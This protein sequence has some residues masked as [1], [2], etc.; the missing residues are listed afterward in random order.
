MSKLNVTQKLI[1]A[2]LLEGEM[3]PGKEIGIKIDQ[4]L[5]QDATGTLVQ[6]EL[7]AMH[8]D[9]A[10]TEVAVQYVDHNLLQTDFKNADDHAFLLSASQKFGLWYSRAGNGVSHPV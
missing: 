6:L 9:K 3:I 2:H 8:L 5:L 10:K 7:E 4:A 1:K